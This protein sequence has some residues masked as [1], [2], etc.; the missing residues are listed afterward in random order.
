[1][2]CCPERPR[3]TTATS[4]SRDA[5]G[6]GVDVDEKAAAKYPYEAR[7]LPTTRRADGSVMDW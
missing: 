7:Y 2:K 5:P 6:L 3:S 1:M 4:T